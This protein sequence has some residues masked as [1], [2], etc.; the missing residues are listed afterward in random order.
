[1][2]RGGGVAPS[3][4]IGSDEPCVDSVDV[5]CFCPSCCDGLL[6][7]RSLMVPAVRLLAVAMVAAET[8][9]VFA[10]VDV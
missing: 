3:E 9:M 7:W 1:M 8:W 10:V 4:F 5:P 6:V 2:F